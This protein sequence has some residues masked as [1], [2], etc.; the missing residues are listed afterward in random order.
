MV[1][2]I[3]R[4]STFALVVSKSGPRVVVSYSQ[5]QSGSKTRSA[6]M[7]LHRLLYCHILPRSKIGRRSLEHDTHTEY[8]PWDSRV[9]TEGK[10]CG[11]LCMLS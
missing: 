9:A 2:Y 4:K 8:K 10:L 7:K 11:E 3:L 5:G 1:S 6:G